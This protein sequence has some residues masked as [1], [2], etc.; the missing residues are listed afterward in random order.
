[1]DKVI[2]I[3]KVYIWDDLS[4]IYN[5]INQKKIDIIL[6]QIESATKKTNCKIEILNNKLIKSFKKSINKL[7][8][9]VTI[10]TRPRKIINTKNKNYQILSKRN[11][12][13][14]GFATNCDVIVDNEIYKLNCINI[15]EDICVTGTTINKVLSKL[16]ENKKFDKINIYFLFGYK[17]I[18][19]EIGKK[20]SNVNIYCDNIFE[21]NPIYESTCIFLSDLLYE[22]LGDVSYINHIKNIR[23]FDNYTEEFCDLI[24][25]LKE[26]VKE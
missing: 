10:G 15:I 20:Y 5:S 23:L 6:R 4:I 7:D 19:D 13:N 25:K 12:G 2:K 14:N 9:V 26:D 3:K 11:I 22:N 1:M 16:N 24:I 21:E 17:K 8:N 18:L